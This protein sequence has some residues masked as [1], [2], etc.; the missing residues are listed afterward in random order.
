MARDKTRSEGAPARR[1]RP[2]LG[3]DALAHTRH[4]ANLMLRW[5]RERNEWIFEAHLQ[6]YSYRQIGHAARLDHT[7]VRTIIAKM[8]P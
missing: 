4:A 3:T 7:T 6:G 5:Q 2:P 8:E 1:G